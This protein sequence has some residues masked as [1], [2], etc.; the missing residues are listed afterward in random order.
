MGQGKGYGAQRLPNLLPGLPGLDIAGN[1]VLLLRIPFGIPEKRELAGEIAHRFQIGVRKPQNA[2]GFHE[3]HGGEDVV[4][5]IAAAVRHHKGRDFPQIVQKLLRLGL[6]IGR[7]GVL[8]LSFFHAEDGEVFVLFQ[9]HQI[10][11]DERLR[12]MG[13]G[14]NTAQRMLALKLRGRA[15]AGQHG[16]GHIAE[17]KHHV[18]LPVGKVL[19][20]LHGSDG[21]S[22]AGGAPNGKDSFLRLLLR[23]GIL[24]WHLAGEDA[25]FLKVQHH[26]TSLS[27]GA[28]DA[29]LS[30]GS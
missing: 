8:V 7:V 10:V 5:D 6:L 16:G 4:G 26:C 24:L 13:G 30:S 12:H 29:V 22:A 18:F 15:D 25:L 28:S 9:R 19:C 17:K 3:R 20:K 2:V 1:L 11:L 14:K 23:R 27:A 21:L